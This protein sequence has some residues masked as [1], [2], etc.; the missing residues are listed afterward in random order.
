MAER[1]THKLWQQLVTEFVGA[2]RCASLAGS[3]G[4]F[5]ALAAL[6]PDRDRAVAFLTNDGGDDAEAQASEIPESAALRP[7]IHGWFV[8]EN[9]LSR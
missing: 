2:C 4:Q 5:Y 9:L 7:V 8:T 3:N 1:A 6:Q